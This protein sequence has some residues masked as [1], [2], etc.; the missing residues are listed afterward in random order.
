M[1]MIIMITIDHHND[2]ARMRACPGLVGLVN[3][4]PFLRDSPL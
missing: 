3:G 1:I 4:F 2:N